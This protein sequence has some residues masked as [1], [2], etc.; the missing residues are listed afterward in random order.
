LQ[1]GSPARIPASPPP[2][3]KVTIQNQ[4]ENDET[5]VKVQVRVSGSGPSIT[6]TKTIPKT[7]AGQQSSVN[8]E[9]PK[10]PP[11]GTVVT[12]RVSVE[13]VR[14][15]KTTTNNSQSYQVLFTG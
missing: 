2:V 3:F 5:N 12:V 11:R 7:T 14:G 15:E 1:A 9:L 10:P 13:P 6:A 4:G 8:V